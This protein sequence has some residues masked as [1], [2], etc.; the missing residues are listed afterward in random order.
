MWEQQQ[1]QSSAREEL[2]G[3]E[4]A[5]FVVCSEASGKRGA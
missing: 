1:K 3:D 4:E 2:T 5:A